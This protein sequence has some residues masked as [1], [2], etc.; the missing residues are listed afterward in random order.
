AIGPRLASHYA[1]GDLAAF[2][3]LLR[4]VLLLAALFGGAGVVG[5]LVVGEPFLRL[6][7]APEYAAQ[8]D[9]LV[10]LMAALALDYAASL[11]GWGI[12]ATR[13]FRRY[14]LPYLVTTATAV[15]AAAVLVPRF[16]LTG[17]AWSVCVVNLVSFVVL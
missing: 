13:Q 12:M 15:A 14:P 8:S 4:N 6:V 1:A 17:A 3:A 7:Y 2:R 11:L 9:L 5:A 10:W 16:G